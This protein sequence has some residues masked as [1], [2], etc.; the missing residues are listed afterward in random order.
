MAKGYLVLILFLSLSGCHSRVVPPGTTVIVLS[1]DGSTKIR[2]KGTYTAF[3]RDR[4]Y[5]VDTK[6]KSF[7]ENMKILCKD[8]INMDVD[9]KWIGNFNVKR[10]KIDFIKSKV[11]AIRSDSGD[12]TGY[13]LSLERFY[14]T[15]VKSIIR[16]LSREVI[17]PYIT[18]A[19]PQQRRQIAASIRKKVLERLGQLNYPIETA[20]VILSNLDYPEVVKNN[21]E[22][23]KNAQLEDTKQ[24]ALAEAAIKQATRNEHIAREQAKADI[25]RARGKAAA[26]RI[27]SKSITPEIL[28]MKQWEVLEAMAKGPNNEVIVVPYEAIGPQTLSRALNRRSIRGKADA[29]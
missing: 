24:E 7:T 12:I 17:S 5:F 27:L 3:G 20:D 26:N 2:K 14:E 29:R 1:T 16:G 15:A 19:I 9:V 11:P 25:E 8:D 23:I 21:R 4:V 22:V 13:Q 28:A 10:E 6:L 18:E